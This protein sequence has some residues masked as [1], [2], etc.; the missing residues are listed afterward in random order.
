MKKIFEN[1]IFLIIL[2]VIVVGSAGV[3]ATSTIQSSN[4]VIFDNN[5]SGINETNVQKA[6]DS[7]YKKTVT[8]DQFCQKKSGTLYQV[9]SKYE[10]TVGYDSNNQPIKYN[11]YLLAI[12]NNY[13]NLIHE[14][15]ITEGT[16]Q[17]M[18]TWSN[19]MKYID[20][21]N[22]RNKWTNV[23]DIDLPLA[24]DIANAVGN[25]S[26]KVEDKDQNGWFYLDPKNGVH[27]HTQVANSTNK[28]SYAW[29]FDYTRECASYGCNNSLSADNNEYGKT[30]ASAYWVRDIVALNSD[31][32]YSHRAWFVDR[33]GRMLNDNL[34]YGGY[35]GVRLVITVLKSNLYQ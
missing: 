21:N 28:S 12:N 24:Q 26:W 20:N 30:E 22:L 33:L 14:H 2:T 34:L 31:T 25:T 1:R 8:M 3:Y 19:A 13:V 16:A 35:D 6:I 32:T 5:A 10:C 27:G 7:L 15:N 4:Q 29:L 18:M 11:F 23:I 17:T 9:G